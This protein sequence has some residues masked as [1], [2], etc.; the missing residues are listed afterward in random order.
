MD[1]KVNI[2]LLEGKSNWSTWKYKSLILLRSIPGGED[3]VNSKLSKPE[4]PNTEDELQVKDYNTKLE[5]FNNADTKALLILTTN[6]TEEVLTQV[7]RFHSAREV[8]LELHRLYEGINEDKTFVLCT[9]FFTYKFESGDSMANHLSK[10]K[11]I[12]NSLNVELGKDDTN[13]KLPELLLICKI[14][15]TLPS[16]YF[17]FKA[18]WQLMTKTDRTVENLTG[19]LCMHERA[20]QNAG[21][22]ITD[23]TEEAL[24]LT[25]GTGKPNVKSKSCNVKC[26]Y[27]NKEGHLIKNCFKWKKDGK[28][29][30]PKSKPDDERTKPNV[31]N[32]DKPNVSM[33][34]THVFTAECDDQNWFVDN[35]AT[36]HV[37]NNESL[38]RCIKEFDKPRMV[39]TANGDTANA[40]GYGDVEIRFYHDNCYQD[41][42]LTNVWLVPSMHKNL[43]SVLAAHDKIPKSKFISTPEECSFE[44]DGKVV[45]TGKRV[46]GNGL[47]KLNVVNI[48]QF[49]NTPSV[50]AV[51][52]PAKTLQLYHERMAHQDKRHIKNVIKQELGIETS[53]DSEL[54]EGCVYGK[55][56]KLKYGKRDRSTVSGQI[57][58][59]DVCGPFQEESFAGNKYFVLF[60]DDFTRYKFI[61]FIKHKSEVIEKFEQVI[62][63]CERVGHKIQTI[64]SDNGGE[65]NNAEMKNLCHKHN[66]EQLFTIPYCSELNGFIEREHR[67]VLEAAKAMFHAHGNL[68][69]S[70]WAEINNAAVY[71]LNRTGKSGISDK[72]PFELW[73]KKKPSLKHLRIVGSECYAHIPKQ[74]RR[75]MDKKAIKGVLVGY[76]RFGYRI[77]TGNSQVIRSRDVIFNEKLLN[78][79]STLSFSEKQDQK[80]EQVELQV[81]KEEQIKDE[82]EL[83]ESQDENEEETNSSKM[84]LRNRESI[85]RPQ[86]FNEFVSLITTE[87]ELTPTTYKEAVTSENRIDWRKAMQEEIQALQDNETWELTELPEN[88]KALQCKWLYKIKENPDGTVERY[89]ARLVAKGFSQKE[90]VDY[91]E[92]FSPVARMTTIRTVLSVASVKQMCLSQFDISTAFLYGK[93]DIND[94][95][96]ISQPEGFDD[97]SGRVCKLKKSLYGLKQAARCWNNCISKFMTNSGF[98]QSTA[99][100]CLF[101][102]IENEEQIIVTLYVD[103]G[104]IASTNKNMLDEFLKKLKSEFKVKDKPLSYFLGLEINQEEDGTIKV[105]QKNYTKK[106]LERFDMSSCR[107]VSTPI[108]SSTNEET[109]Q[110]EKEVKNFPYRQAVGALMFLMLSTRPDI[111][112]AIGVASRKLENPSQEDIVKVKRIFRYLKGTEDCQ[113]VYHPNS[114]VKMEGYSDADLGGDL[115]TGRS[116]TGVLC[117]YAGGPISWISQRQQSVALSTTEAELVA[118]S[119]ATRE[120]VWIRRLLEELSIKQ[121]DPILY[122]D[123]E[124]AIKLAKNPEFHKRTKHIRIR[125]FFVREIVQKGL[126][127][128][129][130]INTDNQLADMLTK[131]MHKPKLTSH[132]NRIGLNFDHIASIQ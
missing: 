65:F 9:Q 110:C 11:N 80:S 57:I 70:S 48:S 76:D 89:K 63:E 118:A 72:S 42:T 32:K 26:H 120:I 37:C 53:V 104:L 60:K 102:K 67:T 123:N 64:Q 132:L 51:T 77:W 101:T 25:K 107:S 75:K 71:L 130:P 86:R 94:E 61:Y 98:T 4:R 2:G 126:L 46:C 55:A 18:S 108:I 52:N 28:P 68:P 49:S 121:D 29:S 19:Q 84:K 27:C 13:Q 47:F 30:K 128:I 114:N 85:L 16:E 103:D 109:H 10:L 83:N 117:M 116:T 90:G 93:L 38:F 91:N 40:V 8:W 44:I 111:A 41:I 14:M 24:A 88:K 17:S 23:R 81:S 99:D 92:T 22:S 95:I 113:I 105:H 124:A 34:A 15:E 82:N 97:K 56:H 125:H 106:L 79:S 6:M 112:F 122:V 1:L 131:P 100:S 5:Y 36:N 96:Y 62:K 74:K 35:G 12:W 21:S 54:C 69:Q 3:I 78:S 43:F 129:K 115:Q 39:T 119:E 66:I 7:M 127:L 59:A 87:S 50:N 45:L 58:H 73:F 33:Y 31:S 20:L